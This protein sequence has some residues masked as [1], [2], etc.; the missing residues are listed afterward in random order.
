MPFTLLFA[1][2]VNDTETIDVSTDDV[3]F[4]SDFM[5]TMLLSL[6][7]VLKSY[8]MA[9]IYLFII[10]IDENFCLTPRGIR[11]CV[12]KKGDEVIVRNGNMVIKS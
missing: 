2:Y 12:S 1:M 7:K 5:L 4:F 11:L 9:L 10:V 8:K 6:Q 3:D